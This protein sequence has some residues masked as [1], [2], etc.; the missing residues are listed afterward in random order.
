FSSRRRHTRFS[1]D[2]SSDVCSSDLRPLVVPI[3]AAEV[4]INQMRGATQ[5]SII[6]TTPHS[7]IIT[8]A[9]TTT[10]PAIMYLQRPV[11]R[12]RPSQSQATL[13]PVTQ[14]RATQL[15]WSPNRLTRRPQAKG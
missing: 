11:L 2:W 6:R 5:R 9:A 14:L 3:L 13:L 15:R 4:P 8:P 12:L 1:R 10:E 7:T